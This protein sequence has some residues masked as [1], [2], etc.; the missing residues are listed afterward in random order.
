MVE[1]FVD[2]VEEAHVEHLVSLV[3]YHGVYI[4]E[5]HHPT[6]DEVDQS[7]RGGHNHLRA[8]LEGLY[9]ALYA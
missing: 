6:V 9:L 4:L 1:D 3:E 7:A 5:F 2:G 8:A